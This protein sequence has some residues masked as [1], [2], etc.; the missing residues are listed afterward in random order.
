MWN[1]MTNGGTLTQLGSMNPKC[2]IWQGIDVPVNRNR[3]GYG[4]SIGSVWNSQ[5][6]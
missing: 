5:V 1:E 4:L 2:G 3:A 6:C